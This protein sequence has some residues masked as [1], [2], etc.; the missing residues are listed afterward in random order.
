LCYTY[1]LEASP[2]VR[3]VTVEVSHITAQ[4]IFDNGNH[5]TQEQTDTIIRGLDQSQLPKNVSWFYEGIGFDKEK[6]KWFLVFKPIE[7]I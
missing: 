5:L 6:K 3:R 1:N 7:N 2:G 4:A